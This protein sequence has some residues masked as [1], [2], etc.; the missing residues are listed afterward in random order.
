MAR[1][2]VAMTALIYAGIGTWTLLDPFG[3]LDRVGVA[4]VDS[5]GEVELRAM[6]GGLELGM[7]LFLLWCLASPERVRAGL[8]A[9]T[10]TVG[11]LGLVRAIGWIGL[12]PD[13]WLSV[14]LMVAEC[15]GAALGALALWSTRPA[16]PAA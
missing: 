13:G 16:P 7:A 12:Q 5:R 15:T 1:A 8:M 9:S 11:G 3:A 4:A 6:Y 10:L 2:L 14:A